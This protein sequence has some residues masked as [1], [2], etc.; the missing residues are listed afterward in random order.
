MFPFFF[1]ATP[2]RRRLALLL[3]LF[4]IVAGTAAWF[5]RPPGAPPD[6]AFASYVREPVPVSLAAAEMGVLQ[7]DLHAVGTVTPLLRIAIR[8]QVDGELTQV[9]F[10]E[11]QQ[12]ARGQLLAEIDERSYRVRLASAEGRAQN[13]RAQWENAAADLRRYQRLAKQDSIAEQRLDTARAQEQHYAA[14]LSHAQAQVDE[15][16]LQLSHTRIVAP[17][18]GRIGLRGIDA[19]NYIR[20]D[21]TQSLAT[22]VQTA[23]TSVLFTIPETRL[24]ALREALAAADGAGLQVQ[25]W[26]ADNQRVLAQGTLQV[27]DNRIDSRSGTLQLRAHFDN[28]TEVL[29]PNQFVNVRLALTRT[30]EV[31]TIPS[32]AVQQGEDGAYVYVVGD[33][34]RAARRL[35]TVGAASAGRVSV[36]AGLQPAE[37]VV[38][39]GID[40]LEDGRDVLVVEQQ[41]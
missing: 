28:Q 25:A 9:H 21:S 11:G 38:L 14:Q 29:F 15:A 27:L 26:D 8:S 23:P 2:R 41:G 37:R 16:R 35:L 19:G 1:S 20:A 6:D 32:A 5:L 17:V 13:I 22:L 34:K 3:A 36:Q 12:V 31:L 33:D 39:E 30:S 24:S 4:L 18:T 40:R 7:R 10:Q